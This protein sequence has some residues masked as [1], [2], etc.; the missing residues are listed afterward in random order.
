MAGSR[1]LKPRSK[2]GQR[3]GRL[4]VV[5]REMRVVK[6]I[7]RKKRENF[8]RCRCDCGG[9]K[10][11]RGCALTSNATRSCGCLRRE[12]TIAAG[13]IRAALCHGESVRKTR[14]YTLWKGMKD[15]C[16]SN[17]YAVRIYY[18]DRGITV[19]PIWLYSYSTFK[20]WAKSAGYRHGLQIDRIDNDCGYSPW[21]CRFVTPMEQAKNRR[22]MRPPGSVNVRGKS[23]K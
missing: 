12:A 8:W 9:K 15:R 21:N 13:K 3:F 6:T 7:G 23:R 19:C 11:V 10:T 2:I 1:K 5:G 17:S 20:A 22:K 4:I 14:L 18:K 16:A